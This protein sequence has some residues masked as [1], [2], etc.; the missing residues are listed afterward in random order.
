MT[1]AVILLLVAAAVAL[2]A[3][4]YLGLERVGRRGVPAIAARSLAWA[5][6]GILLVNVSCP[7][8]AALRAPIVLL[9][10]SLSLGAAGGQWAAAHQAAL[11]L[12][13]VRRFGDERPTDDSLP[14]RGRSL[15]SSALTAAAAAD[16]PLIVVTDGEVED[17]RDIAPDI[18]ARTSVRLFPRDSV[19][20]LAVTSASAP[21]RVTAGDSIPIEVEV[22]A[23]KAFPAGEPRLEIT[24]GRTRLG[25]R[26][27]RLDRSGSVR[28]RI[29]VPS[30]PLQPG[31]H[32]LRIALADPDSEPRT[33]ARLLIV[34]V[35][36]TPGIVLVASPGDWDARALYRAL[37]DVA[38]LPVRGYVRVEKDRWRSMK[39]LTPVDAEAVRRSARGAD[40][41]I[42]KGA[43]ASLAE[44]SRARG[45]WLWPSG[46]SG[47]TL[48]E[49]DW[50]L[51]AISTTPLA[52]AFLGL[53][54]DS[55]PPAIRITPIEPGAGAWVAL[56]A[57]ES[58]R[59]AHRPV[60]TG[61]ERGRV[62]RLTV[63][64]DGL[65]RW[66]FRGGSSEQA[67]RAWVGAATSWLLSGA[68]SARGVARPVRAVVQN[69]RPIHFAWSPV[70]TPRDVAI[71]LTSTG[72]ARTDTLRFDGSGR[73]TLWLAPGEYRY[74]LSD[75]GSGTVAVEEYSDELVSRPVTLVSREARVPTP[76]GRTAVR[77]WVW[78]F[79]LAI[80]ALSIEW[81]WRRRMGLR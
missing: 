64:V 17:T 73:A 30:A 22:R 10:A 55:F 61:E 56:E 31:D 13:D 68:D 63:A 35:A 44:G 81:I 52:G 39:D 21:A 60:V 4:T 38:E 65:W 59:G 51:S 40:L 28:L 75:G 23:L 3:F 67:Y 62:R 33:D 45:L 50:Y 79:G 5:I 9:D 74:R 24:A 34:S 71:G 72:G 7:R 32:V 77:D 47:E 36:A 78:L 66:A 26:A 19:P 41:L 57:Q 14:S 6:L 37:T 12:G 27:V 76:A 25:T 11:G 54:V 18:L 15:L 70:S 43:A 8:P 42:A 53:P 16:R 46:E 58:R 2:A 49:G 80:A 1:G 20:D 48:L 29:A 69:G